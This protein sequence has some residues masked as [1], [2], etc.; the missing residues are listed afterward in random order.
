MSVAKRVT[1]IE[2]SLTPLQAVLLWLTEVLPLDIDTFLEKLTKCPEHEDP[3]RKIQEKVAKAVRARCNKQIMTP[4]EAMNAEFQ[5]RKQAAFLFMLVIDL[6]IAVLGECRF[7]P[8]LILIDN[9]RRMQ[10]QLREEGECP[11]SLMKKITAMVELATE[12]NKECLGDKSVWDALLA[13]L[14]LLREAI[15]AISQKY[16][17][18]RPV[19]V[20]GAKT[21]L[22]ESIEEL[23]SLA[24]AGKESQPQFTVDLAALESS[25][26]DQVVHTVEALVVGTEANVLEGLGQS[27]VAWKLRRQHATAVAERRISL[28]EA[29]A[30]TT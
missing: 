30:R 17:E 21:L 12:V 1:R 20:A 9:L 19:L 16:F 3:R 18:G 6:H 8:W 13:R 22:D 4:A 27:G 7:G 15:A 5:A 25:I 29:R 24:L 23:R 14:L 28:C 10:L 11:A 2:T 26:R